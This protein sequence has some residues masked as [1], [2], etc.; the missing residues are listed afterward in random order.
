VQRR[1]A[2]TQNLR[3]SERQIAF[4]PTKAAAAR[5]RGGIIC[6]RINPEAPSPATGLNAL[7]HE[8]VGIQARAKERLVD[9]VK[10]VVRGELKEDPRHIT[11]LSLN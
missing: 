3:F 4:I 1:E 7:L 5:S 11:E 10:K 2:S 8:Q 9:M 6:C